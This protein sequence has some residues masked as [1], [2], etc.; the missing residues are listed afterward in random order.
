MNFSYTYKHWKDLLQ[1]MLLLK[2]H[3]P[4]HIDQGNTREVCKICSDLI[5]QIPE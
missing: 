1:K 5:T 3:L 4:I 2:R